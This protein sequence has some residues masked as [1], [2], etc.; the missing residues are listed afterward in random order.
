LVGGGERWRLPIALSIAGSDSGG[1]A[2][3]Q[4]DLKTFLALGVYGASA[5]TAVTAQNTRGVRAV[6]S[7]PAEL[8]A[9]QIDVVAEDLGVDGAKTGMLA[10][11]EIVLVVAERVRRWRLQDRLVV[12][13]VLVSSS[14]TR[15]LDERAIGAL[16]RE[17]LPLAAVVTPNVPEAEALTGRAMRSDEEVRDAAQRIGEMGPAAVVIKGG[18]AEGEPVDVL[19]DGREF[20]TFGGRRIETR[21]THGTGCTFSAAL[22]ALLARGSNLVGAVTQAKAYVTGALEHAPGIGHGHGPLGHDWVLE[23][24][25]G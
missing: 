11:E 2:G 9:A 18:H 6:H 15:L 16:V 20:H 3:I 13:P 25:D 12:D 1:G 23:R 7:V 8:V 14:G 10:S 22:A 24:R 4:A 5:V 17:L 21:H 19:W